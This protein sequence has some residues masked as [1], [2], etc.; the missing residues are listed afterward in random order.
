MNDEILQRLSWRGEDT[1]APGQRHASSQQQMRSFHNVA[2]IE[3]RTQDISANFTTAAFL[4]HHVNSSWI[5]GSRIAG[6]RGDGSAG[7]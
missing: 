2:A 1:H 3:P 6:T 5:Y 4:T 7:K